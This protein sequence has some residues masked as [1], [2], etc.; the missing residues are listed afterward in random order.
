MDKDAGWRVVDERRV[1]VADILDGLRAEAVV[2]AV[3]LRRAGPSAT[4]ART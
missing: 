1:V 3:A 4:W 2:D